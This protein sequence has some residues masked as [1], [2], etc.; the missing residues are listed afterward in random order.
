MS[1]Q[2]SAEQNQ[3]SSR[4][5]TYNPITSNT[6]KQ[7]MPKPSF[8]LTTVIAIQSCLFASLLTA[9]EPAQLSRI[10]LK[11][12]WGQVLFC[13]KIYQ[14]T[15]VKP[16]LYDFDTEQCDAAEQLVQDFISKYPRSDRQALKIDAEEHARAL[17]HNSSEPYH[18][19]PA[20][21]EYCS[22]LASIWDKKNIEKT[23]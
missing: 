16:R 14:M 18:S 1:R 4:L 13:Q 20:C 10:E 11:D 21:R 9:A 6:A 22:K 3:D 7:I 17:S 2:N 8:I 23:K 19:V 5:L 12:K 15:E